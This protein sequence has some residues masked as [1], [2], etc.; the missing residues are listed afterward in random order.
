MTP[1]PTTTILAALTIR[2]LI[3]LLTRSFFQPD[4]YFQAL[5]PAHNFVFGY[6]TL[7]WEWLTHRPIRSV[8]YPALNIP[9]Y[10]LLKVLKLDHS[11]LLVGEHPR[12]RLLWLDVELPIAFR[13]QPQGS[14]TAHLHP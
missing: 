3:A 9:I 2:I 11:W 5:E 13:L 4:E 7:T 8:I 14:C 12:I 1:T 10:W 6:G